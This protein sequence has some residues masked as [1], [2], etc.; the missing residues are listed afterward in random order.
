VKIKNDFKKC[1]L[2]FF[3]VFLLLGSFFNNVYSTNEVIE[4]EKQVT[5]LGVPF[6]VCYEEKIFGDKFFGG[7]FTFFDEETKQFA[8]LAHSASDSAGNYMDLANK[9]VLEAE[10]KGVKRTSDGKLNLGYLVFKISYK[11]PNPLNPFKK[12]YSVMGEVLKNNDCGVYGRLN[13]KSNEKFKSF[14]KMSIA[15]REEV[16]IGDAQ[17]LT[18]LEGKTPKKIKVKILGFDKNNEHGIHFESEDEILQGQSGS[19]IVQNKKIVGAICS[20]TID[21]RPKEGFAT[22]ADV[23]YEE[24]L[25]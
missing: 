8:S 1:L 4:D 5:I 9:K 20:N 10:V 18:T 16:E 2:K 11:F 17:L 22:F 21:K 23:M 24:M 15:N 14:S 19:P 13:K 25:K 7:T 6:A 3:A 12:N